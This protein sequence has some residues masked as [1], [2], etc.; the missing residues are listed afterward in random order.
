MPRGGLENRT[1]GAWLRRMSICPASETL[2]Y[3]YTTEENGL[4]L[5]LLDERLSELRHKAK[6]HHGQRKTDRAMGA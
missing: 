1:S 6:M 2:T 5:P 4:I 3:R